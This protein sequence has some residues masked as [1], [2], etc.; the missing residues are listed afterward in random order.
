LDS[1]PGGGGGLFD[2]AIYTSTDRTTNEAQLRDLSWE[3]YTDVNWLFIAHT[4]AVRKIRWYSY[5]AIISMTSY[6]ALT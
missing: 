5:D 2:P 3:N 4:F 1:A 6:L